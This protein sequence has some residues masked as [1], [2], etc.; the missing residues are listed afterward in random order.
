MQQQPFEFL[1]TYKILV[2]ELHK[3]LYGLK[4]TSRKWCNNL[5]EALLHFGF[6]GSKCYYSLLIYFHQGIIL[7][8]I[9]YVDDI[10]II[11]SSPKSSYMVFYLK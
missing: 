10:L 9:V 2:C 4:Q 3:T 5:H 11:D 8:A 7:Y 6:T 1:N